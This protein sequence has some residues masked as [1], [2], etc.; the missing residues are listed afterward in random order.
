MKRYFLKVAYD[1]T[2][3]HGSQ[4]QGEQKTVQLALNKALSTL[5]Q[6]PIETFGASR[7]DEGVHALGNIYHFDFEGILNPQISYK[8]N[9]ILPHQIAVVAL[10]QTK[11][12]DFNSRFDAI[13][14]T[15]RYKIY[16]K[17]DPF[18]K[19]RALFYPYPIQL[20]KLN[21]T[22]SAL[23][24]YTDFESFSKKNTQT[25]TFKC[26][27]FQSFWELRDGELHYVVEANRFLRGMVRA[28][29][30]TQ[31]KLMKKE[32]PIQELH[33]IVESKDCK[34]ADFS[35][36]GNGLYLESVNYPDGALNALDLDNRA[37]SI[38]IYQ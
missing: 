5:L 12:N 25:Y 27:I 1:G 34:L 26:T 36:T 7:T 23:K 16:Q 35:V 22:A 9:A 30:G 38:K 33:K 13:S 32:N 8:L 17:K 3:F 4:I 18:K 11:D 14:R 15:Y 21:Q 2:A 19:D 10:F 20:E 6:L 37:A 24:H 31:L 28:L 29:V